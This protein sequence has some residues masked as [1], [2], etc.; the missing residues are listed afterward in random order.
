MVWNIQLAD[1]VFGREEEEAVLKV[2]RSG[3]LTQGE[4]TAAFEKEFANLVGTAHGIAVS[5]GT[6]ALTLALAALDAP[7][8]S[9]VIVPSLTFVATASAAVAA[10]L[11]PVFA[12]VVSQDDLTLNPQ[13]VARRLT[14]KTVAVIPV[15][16]AGYAADIAGLKSVTSV[17][18]IEDCAHAPGAFGSTGDGQYGSVGGLGDVGCFSFF[19]NKNITVGEG[20]MLTTDNGDLAATLRLLRSHSMTTNTWTRHQGHVFSYDVARPGWNFRIDEMR[21]ALGRCQLARLSELNARRVLLVHRY[22]QMFRKASIDGLA[23]PFSEQETSAPHLQVVLLPEGLDRGTVMANLRERGIQSS[24]H[25]PP[26]HRFQCYYRPE[27]SQLP[28]TDSVSSRL[29]TLPLH[30]NMSKTDV[31]QVVE[32][33]TAAIVG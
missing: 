26:A 25:Y 6:A 5:S 28:V 1:V 18:I 4:V 13:D 2:L 21:S 10:G 29:L 27:V 11:V 24:I 20:G 7:P 15:H 22:I 32:V 31:D 19:S 8:G 17:A 16:Y 3:W 14:E 12:D 9:E 23:V 30:P 33:L